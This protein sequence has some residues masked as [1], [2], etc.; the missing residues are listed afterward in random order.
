MKRRRQVG[1]SGTL[2]GHWAA[3][4]ECWRGTISAVL[5]E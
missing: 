3:D 5:I 2:D 1:D 4:T